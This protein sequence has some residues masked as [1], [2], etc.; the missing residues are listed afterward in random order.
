LGGEKNGDFET[1]K[2]KKKRGREISKREKEEESCSPF[3]RKK[4]RKVLARQTKKKIS[5]FFV[6]EGNPV[7]GE[8][9]QL[10]S[11]QNKRGKKKKLRF[12]RRKRKRKN[13]PTRAPRKNREGEIC[14]HSSEGREN[15]SKG[16]KD[17]NPP[18]ATRSPKGGRRPL[19]E[20]E[21]L[22]T[23]PNILLRK[24]SHSLKGQEEKKKKKNFSFFP[25]KGKTFSKKG[26]K[27]PR[28]SG[29][30]ARNFQKERKSRKKGFSSR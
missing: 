18:P 26:E 4:K 6:E 27:F 11:P 8:E 1:P 9:K 10:S 21:L 28:R 24:F 30:E 17:E 7:S 2:S 19:P 20:R 14:F 16:G 23:L 25:G 29:Q 5:I 22:G 3:S 15:K 12:S 13:L